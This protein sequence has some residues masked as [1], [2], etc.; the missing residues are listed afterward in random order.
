M[1]QALQTTEA[2]SAEK[3]ESPRDG[4]SHGALL[5]C[6]VQTKFKPKNCN[7]SFYALGLV[8]L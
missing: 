4:K 2:A 8:E 5:R 3:H 6:R 1:N 7:N